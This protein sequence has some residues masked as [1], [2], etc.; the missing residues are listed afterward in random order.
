MNGN[1]DETRKEEIRKLARELGER[2]R[3]WEERSKK[4]DADF[5]RQFGGNYRENP[6]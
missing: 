3:E 4:R 6:M 5:W 2:L 1:G